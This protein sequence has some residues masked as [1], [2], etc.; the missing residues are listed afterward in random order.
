ML[1]G[2]RDGAVGDELLRLGEEFAPEI[3]QAPERPWRHGHAAPASR[4]TVEHK[5]YWGAAATIGEARYLTAI[6]NSPVLGEIVAPYQSRGAFGARDFDKYVWYPPT[7][8][9]DGE[10][11]DHRRLAELAERAE[12]IVAAIEIAPGIGFQRARGLLRESLA[13][14]GLFAE[15]DAALRSVLTRSSG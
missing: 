1:R 8:E 3:L 11:P 6:L 10:N 5:L 2:S 4:L 15:V 7:P 9:Y 13:S 14:E 12:A